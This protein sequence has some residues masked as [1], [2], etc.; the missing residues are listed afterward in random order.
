MKKTLLTL[1]LL[2]CLSAIAQTKQPTPVA[3]SQQEAT[4]I[5]ANIQLNQLIKAEL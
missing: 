2:G 5:V 4:I 1:S 3:I